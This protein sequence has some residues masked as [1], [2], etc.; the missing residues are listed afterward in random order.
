MYQA[1]MNNHS[2]KLFTK[3]VYVQMMKCKEYPR[4]QYSPLLFITHLVT[5]GDNFSTT[6][7]LA[8]VLG[9]GMQLCN[10]TL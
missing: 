4:Y 5:I 1:I 3:S 7:Q 8:Q 2:S 6:L 9:E 10:A